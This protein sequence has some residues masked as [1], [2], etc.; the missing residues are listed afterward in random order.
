MPYT[1]DSD[2]VS[3][4]LKHMNGDHN[5]DNLLIARAFDSDPDSVLDAVMTDFDGDGGVWEVS[6]AD[7]SNTLRLPWP[8]GPISERPE[9]RREIVALYKAAHDRLGS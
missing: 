8:N 1:F 6:R 9:I 3:A 2:I 7:S 4:V 5:D